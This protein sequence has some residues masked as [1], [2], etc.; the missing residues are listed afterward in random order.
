MTNKYSQHHTRPLLYHYWRIPP[1]PP[2][3]SSHPCTKKERKKEREKERKKDK[4]RDR[5]KGRK[6]ERKKER[7]VKEG[8]KEGKKKREGNGPTQA[9]IHVDQYQP[10][11]QRFLRSAIIKTATSLCVTF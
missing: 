2:P 6:K 10:L 11:E 9:L 7:K 3:S 8:K 4:K 1:P 5:E